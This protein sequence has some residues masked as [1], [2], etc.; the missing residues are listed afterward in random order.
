MY[1][2]PVR[3]K[4]AVAMYS[5]CPLQSGSKNSRGEDYTLFCSVLGS[6]LFQRGVK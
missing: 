6:R 3:H 2:L 1:A 4:S 5:V